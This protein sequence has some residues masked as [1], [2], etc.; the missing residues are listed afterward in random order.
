MVVLGSVGA[1]EIRLHHYNM[2]RA[3]LFGNGVTLALRVAQ[4]VFLLVWSE[5]TLWWARRCGRVWERHATTV[6]RAASQLRK[7]VLSV[8]L[9]FCAG[10][11]VPECNIPFIATLTLGRYA[12]RDASDINESWYAE[13]AVNVCLLLFGQ[14]L[15]AER[16][17]TGRD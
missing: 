13:V 9:L 4:V 7:S 1:A 3:N 12:N 8:W 10:L 16:C 6:G 14:L 2:S 5:L 11:C 17:E 15:L